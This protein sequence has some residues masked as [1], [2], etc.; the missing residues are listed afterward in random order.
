MMVFREIFEREGL[1]IFTETK[2]LIEESHVD[3]DVVADIF[4]ESC[5]CGWAVN[6]MLNFF[7][8]HMQINKNRVESNV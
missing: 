7:I 8:L 6:G 4:V 2:Q 1:A 3:I 5:W